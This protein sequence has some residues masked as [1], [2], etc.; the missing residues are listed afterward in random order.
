MSQQT[1]LPTDFPTPEACPAH[2]P[3]ALGP[4][5]NNHRCQFSFADGRSCRMLRW[6]KHRLYCLPHA[7]EEERLLAV[8]QVGCELAS[9]S[10]EFNTV[11][12]IN[13]V[14]GKVFALLAHNRIARRD[15]IAYAYVGQ[16]LL[17]TIPRVKSE[18]CEVLGRDAWKEKLQ[19][20]LCPPVTPPVN[21]VDP[22]KISPPVTQ[23]GEL[24]VAQ[25]DAQ[26]GEEL[27]Q[28]ESAQE[29][30]QPAVF[31]P[32][33]E[34]KTPAAVVARRVRALLGARDNRVRAL[35][36]ARHN[37]VP[38]ARDPEQCPAPTPTNPTVAPARAIISEPITRPKK[39][40]IRPQAEPRE[41]YYTDEWG[42]RYRSS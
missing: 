36:G 16:L 3:P 10:G 42:T 12:D 31:D 39:K 22:S 4:A 8:D 25:A 1:V 38:Q 41:T 27:V 35:L 17:Q 7:R 40:R 32:P 18:V 37:E 15:A 5:N 30:L 9:L 24:E 20:A 11:S 19:A 23:D 13:H 2:L 34:A 21:E 6:R 33:A 26:L 14:L 29:M 28:A